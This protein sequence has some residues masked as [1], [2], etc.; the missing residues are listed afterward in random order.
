MNYLDKNGGCSH[1]CVYENK[2]RCFCRPDFELSSDGKNCIEKC[3]GNLVHKNFGSI[4]S[5]NY[6]ENYPAD[7]HCIW[8]IILQQNKIFEIYEIDSE[9][10]I[11]RGCRSDY[12][13]IGRKAF[14]TN[15]NSVTHMFEKVLGAMSRLSDPLLKV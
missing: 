15:F 1:H 13:Q 5:P 3:G 11:T 2:V 9:I 8:N 10:D 4:S 7:Q 12:I 14:Q 6:P